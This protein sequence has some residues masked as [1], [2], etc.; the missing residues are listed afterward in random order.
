MSGRVYLKLTVAGT[1]IDGESTVT[2]IG[3]VDVSKMIECDGY[4]EG[5]A[6][7]QHAT[8]TTPTGPRVYEPIVIRKWVDKSSP[9]LEKAL[10]GTQK[11]VGEF[12]F[13]RPSSENAQMEHF[14]LVKIEDARISQIRR[15]LPDDT[16]DIARSGRPPSE[17]VSFVFSKITWTHL[18]GDKEH[19]DDWRNQS[20]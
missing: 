9:E 1:A 5:V 10:C 20:A 6:T 17:T 12:Y 19:T 18:P 8:S 11:A 15:F 16:T 3:G 14:F 7:A 13:F 4:N 2:S